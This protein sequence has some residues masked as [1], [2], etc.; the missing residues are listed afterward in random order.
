MEK[1]SNLSLLVTEWV[2]KMLD[3]VQEKTGYWMTTQM[4]HLLSL[5]TVNLVLKMGMKIYQSTQNPLNHF[6]SEV[7]NNF[8]VI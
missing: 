7:M 4:L 6:F 2:R 3:S 5:E 1:L 8:C